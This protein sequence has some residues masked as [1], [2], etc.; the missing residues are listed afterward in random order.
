M[1]ETIDRV[2]YVLAG[3]RL[4]DIDED[5]P[6]YG[7]KVESGDLAGVSV[8][9]GIDRSGGPLPGGAWPNV[10]IEAVSEVEQG[11]LHKVVTIALSVGVSVP[12]KFSAL[13]GR[14]HGVPIVDLV[15]AV[16]IALA[17]NKTL[18]V[19]GSHWAGNCQIQSV[20]YGLGSD[21]N[22]NKVGKRYG[23]LVVS[24]LV[25]TETNITI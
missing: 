10:V 19:A 15:R 5:S 1:R 13:F 22:S 3:I 23:N 6:E 7:V 25:P 12:G 17:S 20:D 2:F 24:Y 14:K 21:D 8:I 9:A 4:S 11:Q 16:K 18:S